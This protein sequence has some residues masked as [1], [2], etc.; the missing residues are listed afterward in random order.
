[1]VL[2][3]QAGVEARVREILAELVEVPGETIDL[4][5]EFRELGID[6]IKALELVV[7]LEQEFGVRVAEE[8][9]PQIQ[10]PRMAVQRI[11][12]EAS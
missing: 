12:E 1:M 8:E 3:S 10:T 7:R 11:L 6:S 5:T 4:E 2:K 9:I